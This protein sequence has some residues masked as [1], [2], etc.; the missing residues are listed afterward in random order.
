MS[1]LSD[2]RAVT[3]WAGAHA[4]AGGQAGAARAAS[5]P[6]ENSRS[7]YPVFQSTQTAERTPHV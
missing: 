7:T 3:A 6:G 4:P 2:T 5:V 1:V